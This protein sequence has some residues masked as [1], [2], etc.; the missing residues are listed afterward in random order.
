MI[1]PNDKEKAIKYLQIQK[2]D[3]QTAKAV[4]V[5]DITI[6]LIPTIT[7]EAKQMAI[8]NEKQLQPENVLAS[9]IKSCNHKPIKDEFGLD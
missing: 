7:G 2:M 1:V 5:E 4:K 8:E 6:S 3:L 9:L